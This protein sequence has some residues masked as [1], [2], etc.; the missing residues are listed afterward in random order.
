M[1]REVSCATRF[2][3]A[4]FADGLALLLDEGASADC[5]YFDLGVSSMQIDTWERGFSYSYDAPLDMRMDLRPRGTRAPGKRSWRVGTSAACAAAAG[6]RRGALCP[7]DRPGN[8]LGARA[9]ADCHDARARRGDQGRGAGARPLR[10][11]APREADL[12]GDPDRGQRGARPARRRAAAGVGRARAGRLAR[13]DH[14]PL[15]RG[16]ARQAVL[17]GSARAGCISP[18]DLAP[19]AVVAA[20][21]AELAH[22][23]RAIAPTSGEVAPPTPRA[24]SAH[25]RVARKLGVQA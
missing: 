7:A 23:C 13:R 18:P 1:A 21:E 8:R 24:A 4:S 11:R 12:P 22:P 9:R 3:R 10:R 6:V 20:P 5:V 14:V 17:R 19:C 25:L 15:A 2:I 16:P